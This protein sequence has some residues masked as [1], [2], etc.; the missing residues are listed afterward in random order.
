MWNE[1]Q[2][3]FRDLPGLQVG[4]SEA[5]NSNG[6]RNYG[7]L[8]FSRMQMNTGKMTLSSGTQSTGHLLSIML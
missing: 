3:L 1:D 4:T 8:S 2:W 6:R 7:V 5:S